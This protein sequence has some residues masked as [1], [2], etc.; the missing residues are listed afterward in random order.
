M[1]LYV[2]H[3]NLCRVNEALRIAPA[4]ALGVTN[5]IWTIGELIGAA[6]N[7]IDPEPE[8]QRFGRFTVIEDGL[9]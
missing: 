8:G 5:H 4:M 6:T 7:G 2:S 9:S 1:A 3:Y